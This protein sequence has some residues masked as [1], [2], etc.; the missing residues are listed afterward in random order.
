MAFMRNP[1]KWHPGKHGMYLEYPYVKEINDEFRDELKRVVPGGDRYWNSEKR[2]WWISDTHLDE[3]DNVLF[4]F[5]SGS[6]RGGISV[7]DSW[8]TI[9]LVPVMMPNPEDPEGDPV[10]SKKIF[11]ILGGAYLVWYD[12]FS[13]RVR[14]SLSAN[15][16]DGL[17]VPSHG[18]AKS[19]QAAV[20][21]C[22]RNQA[23]RKEVNNDLRSK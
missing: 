15:P 2:M 8:R 6:A 11:S 14:W 17:G 18:A 10:P 7:S 1:P 4:S 22:I 19:V 12:K 21:T 3:V 16:D 20:R 9:D 5:L 23:L 13:D